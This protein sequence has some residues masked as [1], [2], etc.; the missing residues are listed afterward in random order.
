MGML[1]C[2]RK[3]ASTFM[4]R[5]VV[6]L[7]MAQITKPKELIFRLEF[8]FGKQGVWRNNLSIMSESVTPQEVLKQINIYKDDIL[9]QI[10]VLEDI[11]YWALH[12]REEPFQEVLMHE[13]PILFNGYV[14]NKTLHLQIFGE[15]MHDLKVSWDIT[16]HEKAFLVKLEE[17]RE[18]MRGHLLDLD[19][20]QLFDAVIAPQVKGTVA[21]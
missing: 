17:L 9:E 3:L 20:I 21:A 5:N 12:E 14:H 11:E 18:V 10:G 15:G 8:D 16:T 1:F 6:C 7:S 4:H 2:A 13:R 19:Q